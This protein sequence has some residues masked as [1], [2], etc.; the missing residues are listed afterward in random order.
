MSAGVEKQIVVRHVHHAILD[1][2]IPCERYFLG[3]AIADRIGFRSSPP[4]QPIE[5]RTFYE[6]TAGPR[7]MRIQ[8]NGSTMRIL[9]HHNCHFARQHPSAYRV[10]VTDLVIHVTTTGTVR[11]NLNYTHI[12]EFRNVVRGAKYSISVAAVAAGAVPSV[13]VY[14]A[15]SLPSPKQLQIH[16]DTNGDIKIDWDSVEFHDA[17]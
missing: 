12:Y 14:D 2:L 3:V 10:N 17:P 16:V 7:D 8:L 15:P 13:R 9:W 11:S 6:E 5:F 1:H 4:P